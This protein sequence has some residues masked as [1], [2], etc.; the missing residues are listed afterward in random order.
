MTPGAQ[1]KGLG[2]FFWG[3]FAT[4]KILFLAGFWFHKKSKF[5]PTMAQR[6]S[7][8]LWAGF[9]AWAWGLGLGFRLDGSGFGV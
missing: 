3:D 8:L 7:Q 4:C 1:F 2:C 6:G 9:R 5:F